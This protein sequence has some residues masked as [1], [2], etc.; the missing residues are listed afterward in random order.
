MST[1]SLTKSGPKFPP[2]STWNEKVGMKAAT[3]SLD[4]GQLHARGGGERSRPWTGSPTPTPWEERPAPPASGP[5]QRIRLFTPEV[6]R[7]KQYSHFGCPETDLPSLKMKGELSTPPPPPP[8]QRGGHAP[9]CSHTLNFSN[10]PELVQGLS[11][12]A[13]HRSHVQTVEQ[14]THGEPVTGI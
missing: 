9:P 10:L 12:S 5:P 8:P 4:T 11:P 13:H 7:D 14:Q 3:W 6:P 1:T 2:T